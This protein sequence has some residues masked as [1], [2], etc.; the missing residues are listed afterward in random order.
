M[1][2]KPFISEKTTTNKQKQ[3]KT[4]DFSDATKKTNQ[5]FDHKIHNKCGQKHSFQSKQKKNKEKRRK[6]KKNNKKQ[7]HQK[8]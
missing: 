5:L 7:Q 6:T 1:L 2:P 3:R 8:M 4:T